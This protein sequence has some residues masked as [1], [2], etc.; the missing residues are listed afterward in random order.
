MAGEEAI[1]VGLGI[2]T[3][4]FAYFSLSLRSEDPD[5][6]S[7]GSK[8]SLFFFIL[9]IL[10]C[11]LLMYALL[12]ISQNSL[13]YLETPVINIGLSVMTYGTIGV[14]IIYAVYLLIMLC[15]TMYDW[16]QQAMGKRGKGDVL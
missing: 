11:N 16:I 7:F 15:I 2:I 12:L 9:S 1:I 8:L 5:D 4:I 3:A 6:D 14:L 10:F 13:P